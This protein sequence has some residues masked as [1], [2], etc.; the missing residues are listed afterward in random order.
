MSTI[1]NDDISRVAETDHAPAPLYTCILI[2]ICSCIV[3]PHPPNLLHCQPRLSLPHTPRNE[4][5]HRIGGHSR[6]D[7]NTDPQ[8]D[9]DRSGARPQRSHHFRFAERRNYV[10]PTVARRLENHASPVEGDLSDTENGNP[11]SEKLLRVLITFGDLAKDEV[12]AAREQTVLRR[13]VLVVD[14]RKVVVEVF[15]CEDFGDLDLPFVAKVTVRVGDEKRSIVESIANYTSEVTP[16]NEKKSFIGQF[17]TLF[18]CMVD[19]LKQFT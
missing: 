10:P 12:H 6:S 3:R 1:E 18:Y 11:K 16:K 7:H 5:I 17:L 15:R 2:S 8:Q 19:S 9:L 13:I 14:D 4:L